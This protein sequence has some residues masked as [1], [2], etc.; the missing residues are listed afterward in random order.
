[1]ARRGGAGAQTFLP[2][3]AVIAVL[4]FL[5]V[6]VLAVRSGDKRWLNLRAPHE[7]A[8]HESG[9]TLLAALGKSVDHIGRRA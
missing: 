6:L 2:V 7:N 3:A 8:T 9:E 4:L 5:G 1:M